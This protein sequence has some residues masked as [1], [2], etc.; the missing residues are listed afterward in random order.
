MLISDYVNRSRIKRKNT[1]DGCGP[2]G[3][4]QCFMHVSTS[5]AWG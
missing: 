2:G 3:H 1:I 4:G 5:M